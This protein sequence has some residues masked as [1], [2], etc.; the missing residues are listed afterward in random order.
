MTHATIEQSPGIATAF[1]IVN[2]RV[3]RVEDAL[4][5]LF[6]PGDVF[7]VRALRCPTGEKKFTHRGYHG[8]Y[9]YDHIN[10]A[11][12]DAITLTTSRDF[13]GLKGREA[14]GV[15]VTLNPIQP[16]NWDGRTNEFDVSKTNESTKDTEVL[17][18][19]W[20]FIDC[21][22]DR[23][24]KKSSTEDEK[25]H[26]EELAAKI[27]VELSAA[28]WPDPIFADSGNGSHLLYRIDLLADDGGLVKKC[29]RA[30][31]AKYDS[32]AVK[33]D[34]SVF[35]PSRIVKLYGTT[36]RKG[37]HSDDRP[38][39]EATLL[40]VPE[41]VGVVS[42][43]LLK[44][45]AETAPAEA[46]R[47]TQ[48][49]G[50]PLNDGPV[51]AS[52][53]ELAREFLFGPNIRDSIEH[54]D[55]SGA[56]LDA[57][58]C[59]RVGFNLPRDVTFKLLKEYNAARCD[60]PW[61]DADLERKIE[62]AEKKLGKPP[63]YLLKGNRSGDD[64]DKRFEKGAFNSHDLP[65]LTDG[66]D[67][68][69]E[70]PAGV[71]TEGE[72]GAIADETIPAESG[73][74]HQTAP[75]KLLRS[76]E[77]ALE[78]DDDPDRLARVFLG[79]FAPDGLLRLRRWRQE[80][81]RWSQEDRCYVEI[82]KDQFGGMVGDRIKV[83]FDRIAEENLANADPKK[84]PQN[85][86]RVSR[87]LQN[88]V[89]PRIEAQTIMNEGIEA[90]CWV[91]GSPQAKQNRDPRDFV[92]VRNGILDVREYL[93]GRPCL[94]DHSPYWFSV[95]ALTFAYDPTAQSAEWNHFLATSF[96]NDDERR[97]L[98]QWFG[99]CLTPDTSHQKF[100]MLEGDGGNGK[101]VVCAALNAVLGAENVSHVGIDAFDKGFGLYTTMGK[102]ANIASE[103]GE[104][105]KARES[106]LKEFTGGNSMTF[107][108][109]N[110]DPVNATPTARLMFSVNNRPPVDDKSDGIWRRLLLLPMTVKIQDADKIKRMDKV[111]FWYGSRG[112]ALLNWSLQG[113]A[114]LRANGFVESAASI[115]AKTEYRKDMN[116]VDRFLED[117]FEATG[118]PNDWVLVQSAYR[119]YLEWF[120]ER[121]PKTKPEDVGQFGKD[122]N[123]KWKDKV[124]R[125]KGTKQGDRRYR[126]I[127]LR[128][129]PDVVLPELKPPGSWR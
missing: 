79:R 126:Y 5:L 112:S 62:E 120:D 110:K 45:L 16:T 88:D 40:Q 116:P 26:A 97:M 95:S 111:E 2:A 76:A 27:K 61:P 81:W 18:R 114:D 103:F 9:E 6:Q 12:W 100:L 115:A 57:A 50:G 28:G 93:A 121:F 21:D 25:R 67:V 10:R 11:A 109:K 55:G 42:I 59:M 84:P 52:I 3:K 113:L 53:V 51:D 72:A 37:S 117:H 108:R 29:L 119:L 124:E 35:N 20:L 122:V 33:V 70:V 43:E 19:R 7:E 56:L 102:L 75:L 98:Q 78:A 128:P 87:N 85:A 4:R 92:S 101:S 94:V 74:I 127:G 65:P 99:Y 96:K 14:E 64:E 1:E 73:V 66:D 69:F 13:K 77:T 104:L 89:I 30:L 60:P 86:K 47:T 38:H 83:E 71:S 46:A 8:Y 106:K 15:Y 54:K 17:A 24:A 107:D 39:R 44:S 23:P 48:G 105:G 63:G 34:T 32:D 31:A 36:A 58:I 82:K 91:D 90:P 125:E 129:L 22:P 68:P 49:A 41:S 123:E 80:W 118:D